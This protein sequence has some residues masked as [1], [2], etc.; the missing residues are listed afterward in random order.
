MSCNHHFN[1]LISFIKVQDGNFVYLQF[2][3]ITEIPSPFTLFPAH[4]LPLLS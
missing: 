1:H 3:E 4:T 2:R